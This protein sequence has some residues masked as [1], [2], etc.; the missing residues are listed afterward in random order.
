LEDGAARIRAIAVVHDCLTTSSDLKEIDLDRYLNKLCSELNDHTGLRC[1]VQPP[2][3]PRLH[4]NLAELYKRKVAELAAALTYPSTRDEVISIIRGL[5][6]RVE[7]HPT[8][9]GF[10]IDFFGE[11]AA[12]ISL[13][14][15]AV[16]RDID[17]YRVSAERV[18]GA[19]NHRQLTL[20]V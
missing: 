13:P 15:P 20:A 8:E 7:L 2:P 16:R 12:M 19:G 3:A 4:P 1:A 10:D 5:I 9:D 11:I 14:E 6:E 18:A 17:Y